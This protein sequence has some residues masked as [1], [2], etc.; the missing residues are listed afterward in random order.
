MERNTRQRGAIRRA[1]QRA[2]RPLSIAEVL[3]LARSEVA[4]LGVATVYRNLRILLDESWL[5]EVEIPGIGT[6]YEL[7]GRPHHHHFHCHRC[8]RLYALPG[9]APDLDQ[10]LPP[11]FRGER[12]AVAFFGLCPVCATTE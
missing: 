1:F 3:D 11:G 9:C 5:V 2:D 7:H 8:D 10:S 12:H 4:G 6:R